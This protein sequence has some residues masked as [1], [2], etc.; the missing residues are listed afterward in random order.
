MAHLT[1]V[2]TEKRARAGPVSSCVTGCEAWR[3]VS[4]HNWTHCIV[5]WPPRLAH[6]CRRMN[7]SQAA[8]VSHRLI[9]DGFCGL[10]RS[11]SCETVVM[12]QLL[13]SEQKR[14]FRN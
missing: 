5:Q 8:Q 2:L 4:R 10:V 13:W 9:G 6:Q 7:R 1:T 11:H 14:S 3:G 12:R